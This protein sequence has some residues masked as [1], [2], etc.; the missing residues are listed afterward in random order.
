MSGYA[1][2]LASVVIDSSNNAIVLKEGGGA[3][4]AKTIASGTYYL[5]NGADADDL[6]KAIVDALNSG[7]A[8]TYAVSVVH[9]IDATA[10]ST[11][12]TISRASGAATF[13]LGFAQVTETFDPALLGFA[14]SDTANDATAKTSTLSAS[15]AW[16]PNDLYE[17]RVRARRW[18]LAEEEMA[19]GDVDV[20]RRSDKMRSETVLY[21]FI[22]SARLFE[23]ENPSDTAA[24]LEAF[25]DAWNDGR[26]IEL[27][28]LTNDSATTLDGTDASTASGTYRLGIGAGDQFSPERI[29][30]GIDLYNFDLLLKGAV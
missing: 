9:G 4:T 25:I 15:C 8:N 11:V 30:P 14:A 24:T 10:A 28:D 23:E 6:G 13:S 7:S 2:L 26:A 17:E 21:R 18:E 29:N 1:V 12:V 5:R 27:H 16:V 20:V 19:S 3:Y 22:D